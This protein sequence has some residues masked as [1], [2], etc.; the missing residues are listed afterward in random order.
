MKTFMPRG[1]TV[2]RNWHVIDADDQVLGRLATQVATYLR[3]KHKPTFTP[4]A[5]MGDHVVIVNAEKVR[6]T[7]QKLKQKV[8][9]HHTGYP[10]GVRTRTLE[11]QLEKFP[12]RVIESAVRGMLPKTALGKAMLRKLHVYAGPVHP[13]RGQVEQLES[14][15]EQ[16][17]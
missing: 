1:S 15:K 11:Q 12:G 6:V 7:G 17:A 10:G 2:E 9:F 13:H 3:G 4:H 14:A 8:Y 5:D 16:S